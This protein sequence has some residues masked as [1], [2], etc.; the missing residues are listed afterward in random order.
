MGRT[1]TVAGDVYSFGITLLELFTGK[2]PTDEGFGEKQNLVEWVQSTYLRDLIHFQTIG[3]PNNQLRLL[4]G[5]HCSHYEG[6]EISEQN[7]M[8]C[9]IQVINVAISCT[10]NS[11]NKRITIKDALS[12]LQNA[13]NSL[14][15]FS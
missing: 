5:F 15:G 12:R 7:Q 1:P 11:S 4:I 6:R 14:L 10:A 2:S 8:D 3:S 13:R 9:L